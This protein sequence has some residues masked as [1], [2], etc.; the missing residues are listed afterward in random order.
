MIIYENIYINDNKFTSNLGI[1]I[2]FESEKPI[3][4]SVSNV[5][6]FNGDGY[7]DIAIA[8]VE[9]AYIIFGK[10]SGLNDIS[11][12][13]LT[14]E[15]GLKIIGSGTGV[16]K[17]VSGIGDF[18]KDGLKDLVLTSSIGKSYIVF[19]TQQVTSDLYLDSLDSD[20][21]CEIIGANYLDKAGNSASGV[22]DFNGDGY[23]DIVL[24]ASGYSNTSSTIGAAYVILGRPSCAN[25]IN[26]SQSNQ[27][28]KFIRILSETSDNQG[29]NP[30]SVIGIGDING[31]GLG[32]AMLN[33]RIQDKHYVYIVYGTSS[34]LDNIELANLLSSQGSKILNADMGPKNLRLGD[35]NGDG[36]DD[37]FVNIP[38]SQT[39]VLL[40]GSS[41]LPATIDLSDVESLDG[42]QIYEETGVSSISYA[43]DINKDGYDDIIIGSASG[44][45]PSYFGK[46][47]IIFGTN[48]NPGTIN[49]SELSVEQGFV[50]NKGTPW[51]NFGSSVS[52]AG[53]FNVDGRPDIMIGSPASTTTKRVYIIYNYTTTILSDYPTESPTR[54]PTSLPTYTPE[55]LTDKLYAVFS[56]EVYNKDED[57]QVLFD[58]N[59]HEDYKNK[60]IP[61]GWEVLTDSD[62]LN[63]SD[64]GFFGRAYNCSM[65]NKVV[66]AFRGTEPTD[67]DDIFSDYKL[68][69]GLMPDEY[70]VL[71][72]FVDQLKTRYNLNMNDVFFT[73]HSLGGFLAQLAV[74]TYYRPAIVFESPGAERVINGYY[75]DN[76]YSI[77]HGPEVINSIITCYNAA[78]NLINTA[79]GKHFEYVV[80]LFPM[81]SFSSAT[82]TFQQHSMNT[83]LQ[84]FNDIGIPKLSAV[85]DNYWNIGVSYRN[86]PYFEAVSP[87]D[88][89]AANSFLNE[90]F[91]KNYN[92]NPFFWE[93]AWDKGPNNY[94]T[95][96]PPTTLRKTLIKNYLDSLIE[97]KNLLLKGI[98]ITGDNSGN[99]FFGGTNYKDTMLGGTGN[100][101]YW[102][103]SG[104]D[105]ITDSG[106]S[107]NYYFYT[108]NMRGTTEIS[109]VEKTGII[110]FVNIGCS[111]GKNFI[112]D[113]GAESAYV[114]FP[115]F[116]SFC[117]LT[118]YSSGFLDDLNPF[119][120]SI[121]HKNELIL[122]Y[123]INGDL[124]LS[125]NNNDKED[126]NRDKILV[127]NFEA[128][129]FGITLGSNV[130]DETYVTIGTDK[131]EQFICSGTKDSIIAGLSGINTYFLPLFP[132]LF[133]CSIIGND[134]SNDVY[135]FFANNV[136]RALNSVG[137]VLNSVGTILIYGLKDLDI[138][139]LSAFQLSNF[140]SLSYQYSVNGTTLN[141]PNGLSITL[142][143]TETFLVTLD[144]ST[145][146]YYN[147][148]SHS[149]T[150]NLTSVGI[151]TTQVNNVLSSAPETYSVTTS[152]SLSSTAV[153]TYTTTPES[154]YVQYS[155]SA[156]KQ[157]SSKIYPQHP[158]AYY[159]Q[160][161]SKKTDLYKYKT[162]ND[163]LQNNE[164]KFNITSAKDDNFNKKYATKHPIA[165]S[166]GGSELE[167]IKHE[168][169]LVKFNY[170]D[171]NLILKTSWVGPK[172]VILVY[173][174][175]DNKQVDMAKEIVLTDWC[176]E[177]KTD[178]EA[179]LCSFDSNKDKIFNKED[180]EYNSFYIWQ[181]K[182]QDGVSQEAELNLL[183]DAGILA[184]DFNTQQAIEGEL[185]ELGALNKAGVLWADGRITDAYDLVFTHDAY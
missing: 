120:Q 152:P 119:V 169:S 22:N 171:D 96:F 13:S 111:V 50:I 25:N 77:D 175:N 73:G 136:A 46:V 97:D 106:G 142:D 118:K 102:P 168:D 144:G 156:P 81:Y 164:T 151:N 177:A 180:K 134:D 155:Y 140:S 65:L 131:D 19:G 40:F 159:R 135:K 14:I 48:E 157:C 173:D 15:N 183:E 17:Y 86:W 69:S 10:P 143:L 63:L 6:D 2:N 72:E 90:I 109:D 20:Q 59:Q 66:I 100:D 74:A 92:Q 60:R 154:P 110:K 107:N 5:G 116:D 163:K 31:D 82:F 75:D 80:R 101:E 53:D 149:Y 129:D 68:A 21:G 114:F 153:P 150:T 88:F 54:S 137:R 126:S 89:I 170:K 98:T 24:S 41:S 174:H 26:L 132:S 70:E 160:N 147:S 99:K 56:V 166:L 16:A 67:L 55:P 1:R 178:F 105:I 146:A 18:N 4:T 33:G 8:S 158:A 47:T 3:G 64:D 42:F 29:S 184:L 34:G 104:M 127:K 179:L 172:D 93:D 61:R 182:N 123:P 161:Y 125:Y 103:F 95:V 45:S 91:F 51:N 11:L 185:R 9:R 128:G 176:V 71:K 85:M 32:D 84:Q 78:P 167:L 28:Q 27:N 165:I 49:L 23:D 43:G 87:N 122:L 115:K 7:D 39:G 38:S 52:Y 57:N 133:S 37:Y 36:V 113:E 130:D 83:I 124:L 139:D 58:A 121:K 112:V 76:S 162:K 12:S 62:K 30:S 141:L 79:S 145:F 138:I 181:D 44:E 35:F 108:H 148:S 117:D 94:V